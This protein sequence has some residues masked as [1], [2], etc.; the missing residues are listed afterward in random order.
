MTSCNYSDRARTQRARTHR[1]FLLVS[2]AAVLLVAVIATLSATPVTAL[3][4]AGGG[5]SK[6][7][8][9]ST[10]V[11]QPTA[12]ASSTSTSLPS[13]TVTSQSTGSSSSSSIKPA[14]IK[15]S[16]S[17]AARSADVGSRFSPIV[18]PT[19]SLGYW[20]PA[21]V[22]LLNS[23]TTAAS[24]ATAP[25]RNCTF[26]AINPDR[27][28]NATQVYFD[29]A[30]PNFFDEDDEEGD[31]DDFDVDFDV[32][33]DDEGDEEFELSDDA[34]IAIVCGSI[35]GAACLIATCLYV[36]HR[37]KHRSW[38]QV[39]SPDPGARAG[40]A[41]SAAVG[42]P[43]APPAMATASEPVLSL[44]AFTDKPAFPQ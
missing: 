6:T 19:G 12:T 17:S 5:G 33:F 37:K 25:T 1:R 26:T 44:R 4:K 27:S 28:T 35:A 2:A 31:E 22:K 16:K 10:A 7:S 14:K 38:E 13:S 20:R 29:D 23:T 32:D 9:T 42:H 11:S 43:P 41:S 3:P 15:P 39:R 40:P 8:S 36:A 30:C 18:G 34:V 21:P 24:S